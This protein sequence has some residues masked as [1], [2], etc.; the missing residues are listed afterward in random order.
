VIITASVSYIYNKV[1]V[2]GRMNNVNTL[3][4]LPS[5]SRG[6]YIIQNEVWRSSYGYMNIKPTC[7][8]EEIPVLHTPNVSLN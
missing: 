5:P 1:D 7:I 3:L 2:K 8:A 4:I 6:M